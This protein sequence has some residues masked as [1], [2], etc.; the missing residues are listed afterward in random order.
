MDSVNTLLITQAR[1]GSTRLPG[2]VLLDVAGKTLLEI[3]LNR[4]KQCRNISELVVATSDK[5]EDE[6]ITNLCKELKVRCFTGNESN[7]LD[8][9]YQCAKEVQPVWVVRITADCPLIDPELI[10]AV[11]QC[12]RTNDVDYCTNT[13]IEHFP[14][15]QDVE[16]FKFTALERAWHEATL[17][18][19]KEHVTPYIRNNSTFN[20]K[21]TFTSVNFPCFSD[22]SKVRM[23]VDEPKDFQLISIL[24]NEY[25][26]EQSWMKYTKEI[27]DQKLSEINSGIVRNDGFLKSIKND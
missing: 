15:G 4:L 13:F 3:H 18:S 5:V 9:F 8:R 10:D 21:K 26:V 7:V 2:K 11:I 14:D 23:T 17:N 20:N 25:G 19:E 6:K 1:T 22:F 12:A 24:I 16:V 27:I